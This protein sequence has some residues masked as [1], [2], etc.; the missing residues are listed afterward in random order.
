MNRRLV[1]MLAAMGASLG[2]AIGA[3]A[4]GASATLP[5]EDTTGTDFIR[6]QAETA[7][8]EFFTT[9]DPSTT[10]VACVPPAADSPGVAMLCYATTGAGEVV[11]ATATINDYGDIEMSA[12]GERPAPDHADDR[13]RARCSPRSPAKAAHRSRST[14]SPRRRSCA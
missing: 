5:P 9:A 13:R 11:T 6:G 3:A 7:A 1:T 14:R 10:N 2:V 8:T 12:A 4:N